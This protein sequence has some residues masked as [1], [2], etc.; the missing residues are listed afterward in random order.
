MTTPFNPIQ[1]VEQE[2]LSNTV[3]EVE[4]ISQA[5]PQPNAPT[6]A[7]KA[8]LAY[9]IWEANGAVMD[10]PLTLNFWLEAEVSMVS[11]SK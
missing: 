9:E 8:I 4:E 11:Q 2:I 1:A 5:D 3:S 7:Q 10:S 6:H